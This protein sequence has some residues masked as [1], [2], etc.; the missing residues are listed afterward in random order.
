[1]GDKKKRKEEWEMDLNL[2]ANTEAEKRIKE[3]LEQNASEE[4]A[5]KI[6]CALGYNYILNGNP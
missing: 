2:I 3:Y 1:M 5:R 6:M 4:L